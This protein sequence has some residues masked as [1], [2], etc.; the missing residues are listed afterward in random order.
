MQRNPRVRNEAHLAFIRQ[1]CCI[2][3]GENTTVEAAHVR[4]SD[5]RV[6]KVNA[7]VGAKP[8][9]SF[10][11]P[12][13]GNHHRAQHQCGN[14]RRFWNDLGMDPILYALALFEASGNHDQAVRIIQ[15]AQFGGEARQ[16]SY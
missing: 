2:V 1:L 12:L 3:C 15:A 4:Y 5:A 14:E 11:L 13:C 9:D 8:N 10:V 7:G 16:R 6:A